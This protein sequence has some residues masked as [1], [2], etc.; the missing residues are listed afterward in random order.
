M[1]GSIQPGTPAEGAHEV[2]APELWTC[3]LGGSRLPEEPRPKRWFRSHSWEGTPAPRAEKAPLPLLTTQIPSLPQGKIPGLSGQGLPTASPRSLRPSPS[4]W[5]LQGA[6]QRPQSASPIPTLLCGVGDCTLRPSRGA[7]T[8]TPHPRHG[9]G[10]CS[11]PRCKPP[12]WA[13]S[14]LRHLGSQ[15]PA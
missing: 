10:L 15:V 8:S 5:E 13:T 6:F 2:S 7:T 11:T 3:R 1:S 9:E 12:P 4:S 14:W